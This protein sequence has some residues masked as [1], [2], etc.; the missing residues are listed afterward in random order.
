MNV[1]FEHAKKQLLQPFRFGQWVR[2]AFVGL[3]AG[4]MS[5]GGGCNGGSFNLPSIPHQKGSEQFFGASWPP[6]LAHHPFALT[7]LVILLTALGLSLLVFFIYVNS[8]MRFILFESVV[9]RECHVR[10]GWARH[11]QHGMRYFVWQISLMLVSFAAFAILIG[12][13]AAGAWAMGWFTNPGE[14]LLPLILG[15]VLL[16]FVFLALALVLGVVHVMTKDFVVPQMA[17][18]EISATEGWRRLWLLLK[19]ETG[20]YAGY[21]GM[22]IVLAIAAGIIF[23]IITLIALLV[24]LIPIGGAGVIAVLAGKAAGLTWNFF[25]IT[26]A[27]IVGCAMLAVLLFALSLISVPVIVFFPAYS[28]YFFAPR[29]APLAARLW[30]QPPGSLGTVSPPP[31]PPQ[32]PP[33]P[34]PAR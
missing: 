5:S 6:E 10:Q 1:A 21:I 3:L 33:A 30:P 19:G 24:L 2:L 4:E 32:F 23:G 7:A 26:L 15:G 27:V 9:T 25:T 12:V 28:I 17:L 29:Y 22:K 16:F 8:V 14:H 31:G 18:E 34:A 11:G 13:P 20:G